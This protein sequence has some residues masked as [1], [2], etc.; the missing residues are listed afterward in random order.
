[1]DSGQWILGR[2]VEAFEAEFADFCGASHCVGVGNGLDALTLILRGYD[3]GQ[4]DE[5]IVPAATFIATWLAVEQ[6]GAR[7]VGVDADPLSGNLDPGLVE[8]ACTARTR[9]ILA[10]HLYGH[11]APMEAL[12]AVAARRGV[13]LI[14]DAAQAHGATCRGRRAGALGHAAAF[15]F[16]PGKNLGA[17][18]DGGAVVTDDAEL[19]RRVRL[20]RNYGSSDKYRHDLAGCN[21]RLDELQAAFL[22]AKLPHL[23]GWNARRRRIAER[24]LREIRNPAM[25]LPVVAPDASSAWHLFVVRTPEREKLREHLGARGIGTG[26]HYPTPPHLQ[27]ALAHL[28]LRPGAFPVTERMHR[29]A[30]SLPMDPTLCDAQVERIVEALGTFR[31]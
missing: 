8:R 29:E 24:Y 30:L 2:E 6:A 31:G 16:Y 17:L 7:P 5:V 4:G 19:A 26:I 10:V 27:G 12:R 11:P 14:E 9:A 23:E 18:G 21:S 22:R 3:I 20:L 15:S 13:R 1:M 28:G 25:Q